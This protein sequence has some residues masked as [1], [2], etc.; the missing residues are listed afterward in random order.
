MIREIGPA[1]AV[2]SPVDS[3][4]RKMRNLQKSNLKELIGSTSSAGISSMDS[5]LLNNLKKGFG[6]SKPIT[7][8]PENELTFAELMSAKK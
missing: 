8:N 5:F 1:L 7:V 6:E 4:L 2:E 3:D